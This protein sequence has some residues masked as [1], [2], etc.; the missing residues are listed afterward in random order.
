MDFETYEKWIEFQKTPDMRWDNTEIDHV[1]PVCLIDVS[2]DEELK[3][4][5]NWKSTQP[6][7]K[8]DHQ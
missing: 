6:L 3:E 2:K 7:L 1:K 4:A 5:F 8:N